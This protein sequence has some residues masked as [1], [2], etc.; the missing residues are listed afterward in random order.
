MSSSTTDDRPA[1]AFVPERDADVILKSSD[2]INFSVRRLSLQA[3]CE[4]FDG[5]FASASSFKSDEDGATGLPVIK[6]DEK[7]ADL[8]LL[9]RFVI[10]EQDRRTTDGKPMPQKDIMRS[11]R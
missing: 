3:S 7:G 10:R 6:L 2:G 9:L 5:M 11:A 4:V 8:D 1:I